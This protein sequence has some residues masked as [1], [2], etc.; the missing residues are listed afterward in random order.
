MVEAVV[1]LRMKK[2]IKTRKKIGYG[3]KQ[4][5]GCGSAA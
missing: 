3:I 2:E 5:T 1:I 4:R